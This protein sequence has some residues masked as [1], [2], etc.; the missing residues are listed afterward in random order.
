MGLNTKRKSAVTLVFTALVTLG[1]LTVAI[2]EAHADETQLPARLQRW[3]QPQEWVRDSDQPVLSLGKAGAFDD[4]H[5]F[6]P[7]IQQDGDLF[8]LWYCGSRGKVSQ[9]VFDLGVAISRDGRTFEKADGNPA[10]RFGD[11]RHSVLTP[12]ILKD[13]NRWRMWFSATDFAN[14]NGLHTLHVCTSDDGVRWS[15]P[16]PA[17]LPG[18]YAPSVLKGDDQYRMW[19]AKV[20][21]DPWVICHA[22]SADGLDWSVTAEPVLKLD[23]QSWEAGRLFYPT[24]AQ[25]D[26]VFVMWYGS[27]W[28]AA[29]PEQKTA[30]GFAV[31]SDG[32]QWHKHPDNPVFQPEP[33]QEWESHYVTSESVLRLADGSWRMWYASR[34]KPPF[35]HKYFAIGSATWK[36]PA[37]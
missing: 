34:T 16:S 25:Q 14:G 11:G 19:Y 15:I 18:V 26:G 17:L 24:V 29:L 22:S 6:A 31:S 1:G 33:K 28:Q 37:R 35:V 20:D 30:L 21:R 12:T 9:R 4:T 8:R 3:L 32:L 27:Y 2:G 13:G 7:C 23:R 10:F 5:I 36:G